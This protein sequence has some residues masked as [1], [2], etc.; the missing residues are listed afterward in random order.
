MPKKHP[1]EDA[2]LAAEGQVRGE[3]ERGVFVAGRDELN[4][5]AACCSNGT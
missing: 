1:L 3:D 2:A 4:R 5:I